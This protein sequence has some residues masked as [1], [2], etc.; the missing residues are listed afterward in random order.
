MTL[1]STIV[2]LVVLDALVVYG[3]VHLLAYGIHRDHRDR[4]EQRV[5]PRRL[6]ERASDRLAA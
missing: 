2:L 6:R 5:E 1:T 3:L 4:I